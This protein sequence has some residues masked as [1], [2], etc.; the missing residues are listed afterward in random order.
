M[1]KEFEERK[2]EEHKKKEEDDEFIDIIDDGD[3]ARIRNSMINYE[4]CPKIEIREFVET[5]K[6]GDKLSCLNF[7]KVTIKVASHEIK[8]GGFFSSDYV[9]FNV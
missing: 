3:F 2:A 6:I 1:E 4:D 7:A 5:K 8:K 9:L